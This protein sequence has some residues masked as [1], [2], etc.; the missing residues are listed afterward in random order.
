M[1]EDEVMAL[2]GFQGH[3]H[4]VTAGHNAAFQKLDLLSTFGKVY[5]PFNGNKGN[6]CAHI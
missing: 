1:A 3:P 4:S 5:T 6:P 2:S